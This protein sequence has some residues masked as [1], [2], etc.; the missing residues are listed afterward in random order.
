MKLHTLKNRWL[1]PALSCAALAMTSQS[2]AAVT[3]TFEQRGDDVHATWS[4]SLDPGQLDGTFQY[5]FVE[6]SGDILTNSVGV[7]DIYQ[8]GASTRTTL[9]GTITLIQGTIS[10]FGYL[11]NNFVI[12]PGVAVDFSM[13]NSVMIFGGQTLTGI[14]AADFD[15]TLAWT[16]SVGGATNSIYYTTIPEPSSSVLGAL[17]AG[18]ALLLRRRR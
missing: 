18:L 2:K 6:A 13:S 3:V 14:G 11:F 9:D 12:E 4:G 17:A 15:N 16:S 7:I 1:L 8:F 5:D 10:S